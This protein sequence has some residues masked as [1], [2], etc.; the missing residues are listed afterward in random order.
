MAYEDGVM[1]EPGDRVVL[2][3][4]NW[5]GEPLTATVITIDEW[6]DAY[7]GMSWDNVDRQFPVRSD[8]G[9]VWSV[10]SETYWKPW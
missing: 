6:R 8:D 10:W 1:P 4:A 7:P 3:R 9:K 5:R 2:P